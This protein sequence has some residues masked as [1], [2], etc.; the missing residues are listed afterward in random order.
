MQTPRILVVRFS[1]LGDVVLTTPLLR[2]LHARWP[3]VRITYVTAAAWAPVLAGSPRVQR[4][5][6]LAPGES[7]PSLARRVRDTYDL[8]LDLHG[9]LR[10]RLLRWRLGGAWRGVARRRAARRRLIVFGPAAPPLPPVAERYFEPVA[11]FGVTPDGAAPEVFPGA[12]D[13]ARAAA[14]VEGD[15]AV[16]APGAAHATKRWPPANWRDLARRLR[17][18]GLRVVAAGAPREADLLG[19]LGVIPAYGEGLGVT[20]ALLRRARVAVTHDSGLMHLATAAGTPV[21]AL[22]GPTVPAF[23]YE[24]YRA[25]ATVLERPLACRP[26]S[27][28]GGPRCPLHHHRCLRELS[29]AAVARAALAA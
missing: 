5:V 7:V 9:S 6:A 3:G 20:A 17:A 28:Y 2:A 19:G 14:L 15:Y 18:A 13:V 27:P 25:P 21:V 1:A 8:Q 4:V 16:L 22:F 26:C 12:R 11:E 10:T 29:P 24:P 23:G